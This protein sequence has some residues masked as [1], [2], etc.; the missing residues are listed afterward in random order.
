MSS[1][2]MKARQGRPCP[3]D[4]TRFPRGP[5]FSR[6]ENLRFFGHLCPPLFLA[7]SPA[8]KSVSVR[9]HFSLLRIR[10]RSSR[11]LAT[12]EFF[13]SPKPDHSG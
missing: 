11:R 2:C 5:P 12:N 9:G 3:D 7:L 6:H 4:G 1:G 13:S 8:P 10:G